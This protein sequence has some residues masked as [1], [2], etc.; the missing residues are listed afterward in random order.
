MVHY[1]RAAELGTEAGDTYLEALAL[2]YAG[3]ATEEHGQP[4]DGLKM[5]QLAGL[6]ARS[7]P[8]DEPRA[9]VVGECGRAAVQ[10]VV[11][12]EPASAYARLGSHEAADRK[13]AQARELWQPTPA[14]PYGDL[15]R[16]AAVLELDRGRLVL[17]QL[18][19]GF[20]RV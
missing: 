20:R 15:D 9:V 6:K 16:P 18:A 7:I 11:Q 2:T 1:A 5:L 3:L 4:N 10:A 14:D 17:P 12:E 13:L 19:E 8:A